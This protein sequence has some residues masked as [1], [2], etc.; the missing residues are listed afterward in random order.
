LANLPNAIFKF[1]FHFR[2]IRINSTN[3]QPSSNQLSFNRPLIGMFTLVCLVV[4][5]MIGVGVYVSSFWALMLL[6]DARLVMIV[7]L[8]GGLHAIC[9]AIAYGAV[10]NRLPVSGGE[11]SYL[12]RCVHPGVGF[13]AGWISIIAGFTAPIAATALLF[14]KYVLGAGTPSG[15]N[16]SEWLTIRIIATAVIFVSALLHAF[17]LKVGTSFNNFVI[18]LK[19]ICFAIFLTI[20]IPFVI[21]SPSTGILES[22]KETWMASQSVWSQMMK[23]DIAF[24]MI[25]SL[26]YASLAYTGFNASIYIAGEIEGEKVPGNK[27]KM[28]SRSMLFACILVTV[29][30]LLLNYVF[31]YGLS[32]D[33]IVKQGEDYVATVAENI[34]GRGLSWLIRFAII[35]S[36]ATGILA[37]MAT[38]PMVYSQMAED[39]CLPKFFQIINQ[40]PRR[41]ILVQCTLSCLV[42]W[43][44]DIQDIIGYLGLTLTACGALAVSSIWFA[45][46]PPAI[47][48]PIRW[49]EHLAAMI[50]IG[51]AIVFLIVASQSDR[52]YKKFWCCVATF[53]TG[54]LVYLIARNRKS[55]SCR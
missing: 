15:S 19:L 37:M 14:G 18:V 26:F 49:Y 1:S 35:L 21:Q 10:A 6:G 52:E 36:T 33:L 17:H 45:K 4:G 12:T 54:A 5:N 34:G 22:G 13:V 8:V 11:Y 48:I 38:G 24:S 3:S 31:L 47:S 23:P 32:A 43:W 2:G 16:H 53:G 29:I 30:Y 50:Y 41:A 39:G 51:G 25:V 40:V 7:W 9:G 28:V 20:G 55:A 27:R 42:V 46:S 44:S